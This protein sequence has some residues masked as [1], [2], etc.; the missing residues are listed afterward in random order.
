[1]RIAY[2][3]I[4]RGLAIIAV[5]ASH[6]GYLPFS[7]FLAPFINAWMI[8]VF[9]ISGGLL[10]KPDSGI[11]VF[12]QKKFNRLI[13]P[14]IM[15]FSLSLIGWFWIKDGYSKPM[16][17]LTLK[18]VSEGF[19]NGQGIIFNG[20]LWFFPP[21]FLALILTRL[22]FPFWKIIG[23]TGKLIVLLFIAGIFVIILQPGTKLFFSYDLSVLFLFLILFGRL[24]AD[25][26]INLKFSVTFF[27]ILLL[28][29]IA[30]LY[31][32]GDTNIYSKKFNYP[33]L[34]V[35]NSILAS[36]LI[37]SSA[38]YWEKFGSFAVIQKLGKYSLILMSLHWPIMQWM[39]YLISLTGV[40]NQFN[41]VPTSTNFFIPSEGPSFGLTLIRIS[42]FSLYLLVPIA[43]TMLIINLWIRLKNLIFN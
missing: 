18:D 34:Y 4:A 8:P 32:T 33:I 16:L 27:S 14:Y 26:K 13:V 39:T 10:F 28:V 11:F 37:L 24:L 20:P 31:L 43:A 7:K 29:L 3:D 40:I 12:I 35:I 41:T 30:G 42:L 1:M 5:I 2:I 23:L 22:I 15:L 19:L 6:T 36:L 25:L 21:Y 38:T 9:V 17:V